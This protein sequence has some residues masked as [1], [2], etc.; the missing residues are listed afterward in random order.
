MSD[1]GVQR[2]DLEEI[3]REIGLTA[4]QMNTALSALIGASPP[5]ITVYRTGGGGGFVTA[6]SERT[7]VE[8]GTWPSSSGLIDALVAAL[9][10]AA[11]VEP[12]L[13]RKSKIKAAAQVLG[14]MARDIAIAAIS[15]KVEGKI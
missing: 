10:Q 9:D 3:R 7:R 14:G 8:L 11:D 4:R 13:D 6:I 15:A 2:P 12:V 1:A 5:Y